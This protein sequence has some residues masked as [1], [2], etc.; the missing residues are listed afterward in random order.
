VL[1]SNIV[2]LSGKFGDPT[3]IVAYF[4]E[5]VTCQ[6]NVTYLATVHFKAINTQ[7]S[8]NLF[9]LQNETGVSTFQGKDGQDLVTVELPF[10]KTVTFKAK[11]I[12]L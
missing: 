12:Q 8:F 9:L 2:Q 5:P 11:H 6:A 10:D 7:Y 3:P 4:M 1:A